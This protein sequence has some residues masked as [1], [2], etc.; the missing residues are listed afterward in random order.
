M[1]IDGLNELR[2]EVSRRGFLAGAMRSAGLA[3]G[4]AAGFGPVVEKLAAQTRFV[5]P[6]LPYEVFANIGRIVVPVDED[7]GWETFEPDITNFGLDVFVGQVFLNG[8]SL[9][10]GGFK[11]GLEL[12]NKIPEDIGYNRP[13]LEMNE[14]AKLA[15]F[16]DILVSRF[17]NDGVQEILDFIFIL[18][19]VATKATFFSNF[20]RHRANRNAEFQVLPASGV[21]TGWDIMRWKGPVLADEE[22]QLRDK[23]KDLEELAGIDPTNPF[24]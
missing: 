14:P 10:F 18:S 1:R 20:P 4:A 16:S 12:L 8:S 11:T 5:D 24:I 15:F 19:L 22:R 23:Y 3:A 9:G 17:E 6:R 21:K 2:R 13:F 7:P